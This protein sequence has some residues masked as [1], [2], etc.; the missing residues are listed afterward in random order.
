MRATVRM[1]QQP[2][3]VALREAVQTFD[4]RTAREVLWTALPLVGTLFLALLLIA[5]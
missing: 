4:L 1:L 5:M 2:V 3:D